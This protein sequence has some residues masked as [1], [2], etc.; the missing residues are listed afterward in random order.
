MFCGGIVNKEKW[1]EVK[2]AVD[3]EIVYIGCLWVAQGSR[4]C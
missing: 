4:H 1:S 3:F 2:V